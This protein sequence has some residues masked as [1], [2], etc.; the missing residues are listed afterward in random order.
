MGDLKSAVKVPGKWRQRFDGWQ[1]TLTNLGRSKD[2]RSGA[3]ALKTCLR[4]E[5]IECLYQT[6]DIAARIVDQLPQDMFREGYEIHFHQDDTRL[7]DELFQWIA[8]MDVDQ[9]LERALRW[10]RLYGGGAL[11]M[12]L[13]DGREPSEPLD[14]GRL[15]KI[16]YMVPLHR[17]WLHPVASSIITDLE[18][19]NFGQPALWSLVAQ[20]GFVSQ[21]KAVIHIDR[22]IRFIG[23]EAVGSRLTEL[24]FWGESVFSRLYNAVRNF[25]M[26]HDSVATIFNDFTVGIFK[27]K[28][29]TEICAQGNFELLQTRLELVSGLSSIVNSIVLEN[30]EDYERKTTNVAGLK[31]LLIEVNKRL[32]AATNMPH[33]ILLGESPSGLGASGESEKRDW[34]DFVKGKQES[35]LAPALRR[36]IDLWQ[37]Q[38]LGP[39][40]GVILPYDLQFNSLWQ[41]DDKTKIEKRKLQAEVDQIYLNWGVLDDTEVRDSRFGGGEMSL[42]TRLS[43]PVETKPPEDD[44]AAAED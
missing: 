25:Q 18:D 30:D 34:Y 40:K 29:L 39:A 20:Q 22:M 38:T 21:Q 42:D 28:D 15:R 19:P 8:K 6:D 36:I 44:D 41:E 37:A 2:K 32:V 24:H 11:I 16:D 10:S 43:E 5:E 7:E 12:G 17:H 13:D 26:A 14:I 1:N 23:D 9:K 3:I 31:D 4:Q 33:T 27:L 35:Q